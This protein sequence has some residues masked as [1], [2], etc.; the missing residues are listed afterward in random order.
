MKDCV[1][2][3]IMFEKKVSQKTLGQYNALKLLN[4]IGF[5]GMVVFLDKY[6][7]RLVKEFYANLTGDFDKANS[8]TCG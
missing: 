5:V 2:K 3:V 1:A 6:N 4:N 7:E 8:P